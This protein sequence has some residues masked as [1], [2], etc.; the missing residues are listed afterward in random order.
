MKFRG[1]RIFLYASG[2]TGT[3]EMLCGLKTY[4]ASVSRFGIY[5]VLGIYVRN[6]MREV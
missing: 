4:I 1:A 3:N 6:E 5:I 2:G